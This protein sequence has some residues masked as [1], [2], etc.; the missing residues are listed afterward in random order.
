[1][2]TYNTVNVQGIP[3]FYREAGP[4]EFREQYT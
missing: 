3:I 1:M 4:E 2:I